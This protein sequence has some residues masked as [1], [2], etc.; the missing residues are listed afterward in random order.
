M[1]RKGKVSGLFVAAV[2]ACLC[3]AAP[4][5][6]AVIFL[7]RSSLLIASG[8]ICQPPWAEEC[9]G[10][11]RDGTDSFDPYSNS[12]AF[13]APDGVITAT[14]RQQSILDPNRIFVD[15]RADTAAGLPPYIG[16]G[17]SLFAVQ[18]EL[19]LPALF[20][21]TGESANYYDA[22]S[23]MIRL[24]GPGTNISAGYSG[25]DSI[26]FFRVAESGVLPV[27]RYTFIV[28]AIGGDGPRGNAF[29][30]A[31]AELNLTPVPLP[32]AAVLFLSAG[33]GLMAWQR[34][35]TAKQS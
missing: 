7:Q 29:A 3:G 35:R 14:A 28:N 33:L 18:F 32:G 8:M 6:A 15:S 24:T 27:G 2:L 23:S 30:F 12:I 21:L 22:G 17:R 5:Q 11:A 31:M 19:D 25:G 26:E 20:T 4:A 13:Q 34:R 9:L 10:S 1:T 16:V